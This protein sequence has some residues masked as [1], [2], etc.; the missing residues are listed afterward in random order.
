MSEFILLW[1]AV[2]SD[3]TWLNSGNYADIDRRKLVAFELWSQGYQ[4]LIVRVNLELSQR[5]IY[6]RRVR[7]QVLSPNNSEVMYIV[8]WQ[9]TIQGYNIQSILCVYED[10]RIEVIGQWDETRAW[11]CSPVL[12]DDEK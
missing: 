11:L 7:A 3:G 2:Y 9:Q 4:K 10:G 5:L 6:R 12:R 1:K 8:G